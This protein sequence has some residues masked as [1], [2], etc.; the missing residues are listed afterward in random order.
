MIIPI[1]CFTCNKVLADKWNHYEE[2]VRKLRD[3]AAVPKEEPLSFTQKDP[4][5]YF[6]KNIQKDILDKLG[7]DRICCRR[8]MIS[9]ADLLK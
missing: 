7:L 5:L 2:E 4:M 1:R 6:D 8:H 9:N 3:A